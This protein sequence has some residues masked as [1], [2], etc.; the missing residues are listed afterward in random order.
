MKVIFQEHYGPITEEDIT[1][2]ETAHNLRFPQ[3]YRDFLKKYNGAFR[4]DREVIHYEIRGKRYGTFLNL[5]FGIK[6]QRG[7]SIPMQ[8]DYSPPWNR[9]FPIGIDAGPNSFEMSL[10]EADF[11]AIY[12]WENS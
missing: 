2:F 4:P 8:S 11:G 1:T 10:R 7:N 12:F 6:E 5:L 9:F 3:D